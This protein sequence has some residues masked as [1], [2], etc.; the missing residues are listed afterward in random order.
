MPRENIS[1]DENIYVYQRMMKSPK[2]FIQKMWGLEAQIRGFSFIRGKHWTWQQDEVLTAIENAINGSLP[3]RISVRS[4]RGIGKSCLLAWLVIWY[5][6][7]HKDAQVPC[8]APTSEQMNDVLWKE[9][10]KWINRLPPNVQRLF[11]WTNTHIRMA[12]NPNIWFA[13]A[14]TARKE[15]PEAL[16]GIHGE[17]VFLVVDEASGVPDQIFTTAEGFLTDKNTLVI[18]FSNPTRLEGYFFDTFNRDKANWQTLH[19]SFENNPDVCYYT[20]SVR[21]VS[22][23]CSGSVDLSKGLI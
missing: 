23:C 12:E 2:Y 20:A 4:G 15:T 8:T 6:F 19:F 16:A 13:R 7:T 21:Q 14:K 11:E 22:R 1:R 17:F 10:A 9:I 18:M 3:K 5:L